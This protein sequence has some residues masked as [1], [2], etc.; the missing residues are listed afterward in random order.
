[1]DFSVETSTCFWEQIKYPLILSSTIMDHGCVF[2]TCAGKGSRLAAWQLGKMEAFQ[3]LN[4][5][6]QE[7][8]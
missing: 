1:M 6:D 2:S 8:S 3:V 4:H 5:M 7:V